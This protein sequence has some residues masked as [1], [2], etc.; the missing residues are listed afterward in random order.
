MKDIKVLA[1]NLPAFHQIPEND[2]WWGEGFT[3]WDNV[4]SGVSYFEHHYQ[5]MKPLEGY[6]NLSKIE[7]IKRQFELAKLY[8]VYGFIY[9]H[10][11]FGDGRMLFEKPIDMI[12]N[13]K[14]IYGKF[15]LC[16]A[17]ETW[18]TTWHGLE[19]KTLMPQTYGGK[20]EWDE[21]LNYLIRVFKDDRYIL[22]ENKPVL[23]I[24]KPNEIT[25]YDER[26]KYYHKRLKEVGFDGLYVVEYISSKNTSLSSEVSDAVMEF[27]PLYTTYF[28][29]S[30]FNLFKRFVC[31]KLKCIDY[32]NY[33]K[34]WAYKLKRNRLYK[35]KTIFK[36]C[37][38]GW[39]N[40]A[41]KGKNS[42]IV[43]NS[44]PKK[45]ENYLER[46]VKQDRKDCSEEFIVINA[47]NEWSEGAYLEPD[48]KNEYGFLEAISKVVKENS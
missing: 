1:I 4:R 37:F 47:W 18:M 33:D 46:L 8:N 43:K 27:E 45:F 40:S 3:E 2:E 12:L 15:C 41:R 20:E 39:D 10:Y 11:W 42:M 24:Y 29:I 26:I 7:D 16:W 32:Q 5:P 19:P 14:S 48:T 34:L 22:I 36:S 31:K 44:S 30:K 28:D 38:V 35:G 17:N 25:N 9:Y 13:D 21:H 6:Y 23:F